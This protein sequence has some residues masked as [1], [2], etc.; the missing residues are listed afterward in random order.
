MKEF[1]TYDFTF[2]KIISIVFR[3]LLVIYAVCLLLLNI[4]FFPT[5]VYLAG[6][7]TY[8]IIFAW[9][10]GKDNYLSK[11]RLLNDFLFIGLILYGKDLNSLINIIFLFLPII[12]SPNHS[13]SKRSSWVYILTVII[14]LISKVKPMYW[15]LLP[16]VI[17]WSL[18]LFERF[19]F[20]L[21]V[22]Q[23]NLF[24]I[25]DRYEVKNYQF[26]N[27]HKIYRE[28]IKGINSSKLANWFQ[29]EKIV[30][31]I[32][33]E[34]NQLVLYNSSDFISVYSVKIEKETIK[35]LKDG[36]LV[37]NIP[38]KLN[39]GESKINFFKAVKIPVKNKEQN[40][41]TPNYYLFCLTLKN[42]LSV[43][44][45]FSTVTVK[46]LSPL[47]VKIARLIAMETEL[48]TLRDQEIFKIKS[49]LSYVNNTLLGMHFIRNKL[50]PIQ[51]GIKM[52]VNENQ[53]NS[54]VN[55]AEWEK[56]KRRDLRIAETSLI[57][58]RQ[59]TDYILESEDNP[60]KIT[61]LSRI[62]FGK[63]F[64][65]IRRLWLQHFAPETIAVK[66]DPESFLKIIL[67]LDSEAIEIVFTDIITNAIKY[68]NDVNNASVTFLQEKDDV[69]IE[70][71]NDIKPKISNSDLAILVESFNSK[72]FSIINRKTHGLKIVKELLDQMEVSYKMLLKNNVLTFRLSFK[73][74][75]K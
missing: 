11:L 19:R 66:I 34:N 40:E 21:N 31:F 74:E 49:K 53:L 16:V 17:L 45:V 18:S 41:T 71:S 3:G 33:K 75:V 67:K 61:Q 12:N 43:Y 6:F 50:S 15:T 23:S 44:T 24:S 64:F 69:I 13:G 25:I 9:L 30:C 8:V 58:I 1:F 5:Y 48:R 52:T 22:L 4:N 14:L 26:G 72:E 35:N 28:L 2:R 54:S 39:S 57:E 73:M 56:L 38:I 60:F 20:Y 37:R 7:V 70:F 42:K 47:L 36:G 68:C 46:F 51:N 62:S 32:I 65:V 29:I 10:F 55:T 59:K 63:L 27:T